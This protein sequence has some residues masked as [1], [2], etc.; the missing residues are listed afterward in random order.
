[1]NLGFSAGE[2]FEIAEQI[3][4]NGASFY[5]KAAD[6]TD[7]SDMKRKLLELAEMEDDH[8]AIFTAMMD[9]LSNLERIEP[10]FD[11]DN[12]AVLYLQAF[13]DTHVFNAKADPCE[14]LTGRESLEDILSMAIGLEKDSIVFYVGMREM[15]PE[16]L[17]KD[18]IYRIIKE[19][20]SHVVMLT[21][22]LSAL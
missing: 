4:R 2:I 15:V 17:G 7:E 8:L 22:E 13:A 20:M 10:V 3:E 11:P 12:V 18:K 21:D 16:R 6:G 14:K 19:E 1:M 9:E 5:R